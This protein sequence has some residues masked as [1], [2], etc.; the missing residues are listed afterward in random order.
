MKE[1][2]TLVQSGN[3]EFS[4]AEVGAELGVPRASSYKG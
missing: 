4:V 2:S 1:H 3:A